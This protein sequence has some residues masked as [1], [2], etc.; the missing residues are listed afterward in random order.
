MGPGQARCAVGV[1]IGGTKVLA[2]RLSAT[3]EVEAERRWPTPQRSAEVVELALAAVAALAPGEEAPVG[4]AVT[5]GVGCPGMVDRQGKA[6]FCPHLHDLDG[7]GLQAAITARRPAGAHT[8]VLNDATAACWAEHRL[9]A[10]RGID[11]LLLVTF[12]TGIGGGMV[13]GGRLLLGAHGFAGEIGHMVLDPEGPEC[14]CGKRGCWERFASGEA[15][16]RRAREAAQAGRLHGAL[17]HWD[18]GT[19]RLRGEHVSQAAAA[20]DREAAGLVSDMAL[21]LAR[22]LANL[23]NILDPGLI[24]LGGGLLAAGET[25]FLPVRA[26]FEDMVEAPD[27]RHTGVVPAELGERAGAVGAALWAWETAAAGG[28]KPTRSSGTAPR[29]APD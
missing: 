4:D 19:D 9:G 21:W 11:D 2:V 18:Q 7:F 8:T 26:A 1:D 14:P 13:A 17:A 28:G 20:G 23:V 27:A 29:A 22:G 15:L 25:V 3:G 5:L 12:G 6:H 10:A 24:V 16:G